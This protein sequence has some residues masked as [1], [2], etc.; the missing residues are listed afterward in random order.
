MILL[1]SFPLPP[2]LSCCCLLCCASLC[3]MHVVSELVALLLHSFRLTLSLSS[4]SST[5]LRAPDIN[6]IA[7]NPIDPAAIE[8]HCASVDELL[9][10]SYRVGC[11]YYGTDKYVEY[12][13]G[14]LPL[15]ITV[16]HGGYS[17]P[18]HIP[19]RTRGVHEPDIFT[20]ELARCIVSSCA[21]ASDGQAVPHVVINRVRR[22]KLDM[23]RGEAEATEGN[24]QMRRSWKEFQTFVKRAKREIV[25]GRSIT[26]VKWKQQQIM[27]SN[28]KTNGTAHSPSHST[29]SVIAASSSSSAAVASYSSSS[30]PFSSFTSVISSSPFS[31]GL[32]LDLHGQSHDLRHQLGYILSQ[33]ELSILSDEVLDCSRE[34][35]DKCSCRCAIDAPPDAIV[36]E[37][38]PA[39]PL[40]ASSAPDAFS[41]AATH[42]VVTSTPPTLPFGSLHPTSSS[43]AF[44]S[45]SPTTLSSILRGERSLGALLEQMGHPCV[46]SPTSPH[47]ETGP[48]TE[49]GKHKIMYFNG[50][51]RTHKTKQT[52]R[53]RERM[54]SYIES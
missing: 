43:S 50:G 41:A 51:R 29:S 45:S 1:R 38:T 42:A 48:G 14:N 47:A 37:W 32:F 8:F 53:T 23:N 17:N 27:Q 36:T 11:S 35:C 22:T 2:L 16:P 5:V 49:Q 4:M 9:H 3:D 34:M 39:A 6:P 10:S 46:P 13:A 33:Q 15:L 31:R 30:P 52:L 20:Q 24:E 26:N 21:R 25:R 19:D 44:S 54:R 28:E 40:C 7:A 12:I 18:A